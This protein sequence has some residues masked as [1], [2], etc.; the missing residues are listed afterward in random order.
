M[1]TVRVRDYTNFA[2]RTD[3]VERFIDL[4]SPSVTQVII[5]III[6]YGF[7]FKTNIVIPT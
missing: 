1:N 2:G 7:H 5:I 3:G 6:I 4:L